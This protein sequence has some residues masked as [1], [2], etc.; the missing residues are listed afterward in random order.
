MNFQPLD[1]FERFGQ[2]AEPLSSA[3]TEPDP[4]F[5]RAGLAW[6]AACVAIAVAAG[7][8]IPLLSEPGAWAGVAQAANPA[9]AAS[10]ATAAMK[11][12][13]LP[14]TLKLAGEETRPAK[15]VGKLQLGM[16]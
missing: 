16:F 5:D 10:A 11:A 15:P 7:H 4:F 9:G 2:P 14:Q 1:P 3:A 6:I 8:W 13:P 12:L